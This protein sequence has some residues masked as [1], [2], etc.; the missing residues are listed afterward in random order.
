MD[1]YTLRLS[2]KEI[3]ALNDRARVMAVKPST[4]A[5]KAILTYLSQPIKKPLAS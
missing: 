5:R 2:P 4:L 3:Q 1:V